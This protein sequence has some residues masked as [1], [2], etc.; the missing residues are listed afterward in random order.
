MAKKDYRQLIFS[1]EG[2]WLAHRRIGGSGASALFGC[3]EYQTKLDTYCSAVNKPDEYEEKEDTVSTAY[4]KALEPIIHAITKENF[5]S[6]YKIIRPNRFSF[7]ERVSK[8]FQTASLDAIGVDKET[9]EKWV[10]EYKTHMVRDREDYEKNWKDM[11]PQKY[12]IQLL[13]YLNVMNDFVGAY[14]V[15]KLQWIDYDTGLPIKEEIRYYKITREQYVKDIAYLDEVETKFY[16]EH[17]TKHIPPNVSLNICQS[18]ED[19][20]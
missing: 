4:G 3:N 19:D 9:K 16:E 13:H 2:E 8:P 17:I 11:L 6:K 12:F 18:E 1:S 15:A 5:K 7:Y 14:L 10:F 20:K